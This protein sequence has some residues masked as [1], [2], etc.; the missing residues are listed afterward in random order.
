MK[1]YKSIIILLIITNM[2]FIAVICNLVNKNV[3]VIKEKQI[4]K[5]MTQS[6]L[7]SSLNNTIN[8]LNATQEKYAAYVSSYKTK[9]TEAIT[10]QGI[11]TEVSATADVVA[12]NIGKIV[13]T[14]TA[15]TAAAAQI[16]TGKTAWVNGTKITGTMNNMANTTKAWSGYE[17]I[18]LEAHPTDSSQGLVT[19]TNSY[20][21]IGYY[22][23]T[24]KITGNIANLNAA[25]IK[26]GVKVGRIDGT[27]GITGTYTSD[28]TATASDIFSGKTAYVNGTKVTGTLTAESL[29]PDLSVT[30]KATHTSQSGSTT[31]YHSISTYNI[32]TISVSTS[33]SASHSGS[34][35]VTG[36]TSDGTTTTLTKGS[37]IDVSAYDSLVFKLTCSGRNNSGFSQTGTYNVSIEKVD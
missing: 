4:I 20:G 29:A 18:S 13:S 2:L 21:A 1:K 28:A 9:I 23:S 35:T 17:T 8:E 15:A 11:T 14:K 7:E 12:E 22:D 32:N 30:L 27:S 37:E 6:E 10:N 26:A 34:Y 33:C 3:N 24:S 19:I 25:N 5:E 16:L 36:T 31:K